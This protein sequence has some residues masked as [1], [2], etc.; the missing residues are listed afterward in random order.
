MV[1]HY[2]PKCSPEAILRLSQNSHMTFFKWMYPTLDM[3]KHTKA[4]IYAA[5]SLLKRLTT[6]GGVWG[7]MGTCRGPYVILVKCMV[8][9][10][11]EGVSPQT[12]YVPP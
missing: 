10:H 2:E 12:I 11:L 8:T 7:R 5:L 6:F 9:R 3:Y 4:C 1:L